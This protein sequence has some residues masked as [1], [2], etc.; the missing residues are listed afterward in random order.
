MIVQVKKGR[1][2]VLYAQVT[3]ASLACDGNEYWN[4]NW[5]QAASYVTSPPLRKGMAEALVEA[6]STGHLDVASSGHATFN[7]K[8]RALGVN[9]FRMIPTGVNGI[10]ERMMILW[11]KLVHAGKINA[12]Q[13]HSGFTK[14]V[15]LSFPS[16]KTI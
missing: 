8:Q 2:N 11:D 6:A 5:D 4:T 9:D 1:G 7:S 16:C 13:F 15:Y 10:E 3:P 12:E 14:L